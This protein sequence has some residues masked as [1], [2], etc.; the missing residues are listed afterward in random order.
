MYMTLFLLWLNTVIVNNSTNIKETNNHVRLSSQ[1]FDHKSDHDIMALLSRQVLELYMTLFLSWC[2]TSIFLAINV[3]FFI[4]SNY[5]QASIPLFL[6]NHAATI[7]NKASAWHWCKD[8]CSQSNP[9]NQLKR[10]TY[11]LTV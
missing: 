2:S 10:I 8:D 9:I 3:F 6:V 1:I 7:V 11:I 4:L 5:T